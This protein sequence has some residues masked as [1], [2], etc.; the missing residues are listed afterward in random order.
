MRKLAQKKAESKAFCDP[1]KLNEYFK[2]FLLVGKFGSKL[3]E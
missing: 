3:N 1:K 2:Q